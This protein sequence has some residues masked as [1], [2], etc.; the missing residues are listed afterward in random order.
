[1]TEILSFSGQEAVPFLAD[2]ARLRIQVFREFPYLYDGSMDD[3]ERY[4]VDYFSTPES[5]LV[6]ARDVASGKIVG[7]STAMPLL[8]ADVAFQAPLV[9]AGHD[10]SAIHYFGESVLLA[11][12]RG[13]GI[14]HRFFDER[15]AAA[16]R[17]GFA[18]TAFCA[19]MRPADHPLRPEHYRPHDRF[20]IKRGYTH[21][22]EIQVALD[23]KE[24][25]HPIEHKH[26][27]SFWIREIRSHHPPDLF[28]EKRD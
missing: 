19:V 15:E 27:L 12:Y 1:M 7:A 28:V 8:T 17:T 3:E 10:V 4:L 23:W 5:V 14:G 16:H 6:V 22:P 9:A 24:P 11:E 18:T 13:Q 2:L 25:D 21:H 26:L 20:W